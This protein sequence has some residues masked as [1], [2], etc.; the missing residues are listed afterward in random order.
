MCKPLGLVARGG[1]TSVA[2][3]ALHRPKTDPVPYKRVEPTAAG[4]AAGSWM[5]YGVSTPISLR[6]GRSPS[7]NPQNPPPPALNRPKA[8]PVPGTHRPKTDSI[9]A[10]ELAVASHGAPFHDA[11]QNPGG[12]SIGVR[13]G[14]RGRS[15]DRV[16]GRGRPREPGRRSRT[17]PPRNRPLPAYSSRRQPCAPA[18][19]H[20]P[21]P[22]KTFSSHKEA[23]P[24]PKGEPGP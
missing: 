14:P 7:E 8:E 12:R 16:L 13:A 23:R 21:P 9:P 6:G 10:G 20:A 1:F 19:Q 2:Y 17:L 15:P 3:P 11:A 22:A 4:T 5:G 18:P 24:P